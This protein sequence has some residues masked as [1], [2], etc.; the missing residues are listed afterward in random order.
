M[1]LRKMICESSFCFPA[2]CP[3]CSDAV[4]EQN[5]MNTKGKAKKKKKIR[6]C[7]KYFCFNSWPI[8]DSSCVVPCKNLFTQGEDYPR[9]AAQSSLRS[10][11]WN[12]GKHQHPQPTSL[13]LEEHIF[14]C[15]FTHCQSVTEQEIAPFALV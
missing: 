11:V 15:K 5:R 2:S 12:A 9:P 14:L 6:H 1:G 3:E 4:T 10:C 8:T 13:F 7:L